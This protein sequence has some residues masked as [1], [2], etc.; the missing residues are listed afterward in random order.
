MRADQLKHIHREENRNRRDPNDN[1]VWRISE[2][3]ERC[4]GARL[5]DDH[6][7]LR[8][9]N[10]LPKRRLPKTVGCNASRCPICGE[11]GYP[12]SGV[13]CEGF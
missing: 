4:R 10:Q 1:V 11:P 12:I 6:R 8:L 5:Q 7:R 13:L 3:K 2:I 9:Q